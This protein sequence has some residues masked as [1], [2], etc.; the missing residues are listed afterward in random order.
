MSSALLVATFTVHVPYGFSSTRPEAVASAAAHFEQPAY[1]T[2][3]LYLAF[4]PP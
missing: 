2:D 1:E 4:L 3:L